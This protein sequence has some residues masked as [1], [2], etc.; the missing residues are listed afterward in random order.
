MRSASRFGTAAAAAALVA[1]GAAG[2]W[3]INRFV[4]T[5]NA[6][7]PEPA[8]APVTPAT[9]AERLVLVTLT[10]EMIRRAG[11]ET[12]AAQTGPSARTLRAPGTVEPNAYRQTTVTALTGGTVTSVRADLG[13]AVRA[14]QV[15]VEVST[16]DYAEAEHMLLGA[17]TAL[18][19]AQKRRERSEKLA[20]I[21]GVSA[22]E[23]DEAKAEE[24]RQFHAVDE[25]T[26]RL[27]LFG[28][29][30]A[31]VA[32]VVTKR[33]VNAGQSVQPG[34]ELVTIS[35]LSTVWVMAE[36][37]E[38]DLASVRAG[39]AARVVSRSYPGEVFAGRIAYLDPQVSAETRTVRARI[40]VANTA[41]KL[42]FGMLVDVEISG[43][44]APALLVPRSAVQQIGERAMV[45][46]MTAPGR[47]EA[48][49]V[50]L[51]ASSGDEISVTSGL[52][53]GELVVTTGSFA[54]RAEWE[55]QR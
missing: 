43:T 6:H 23:V 54:L 44:S 41:R 9:T 3:A 48:R 55:R 47:Y 33:A 39:A 10:P 34:A 31:P 35:D 37:Y 21:G 1:I 24:S 13:E 7:R 15:L 16:R 32:G 12:V 38:R 29:V 30:R 11:I 45:F 53:N 42:R 49:D 28:P 51:G 8:A 25:A 40:D 17:Q 22:Q 2:F 4:W 5:P 52:A 36:I 27:R 46:V 50:I 19:V 14:G 18:D 26:A 20:A